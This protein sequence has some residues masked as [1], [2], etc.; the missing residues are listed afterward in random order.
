MI[1]LQQVLKFTCRSK[2][3]VYQT[4]K[5]GVKKREKDKYFKYILSILKKIN[6]K[7]FKYI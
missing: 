3:N 6:D 2:K 1:K 7:Y 5:N 4:K